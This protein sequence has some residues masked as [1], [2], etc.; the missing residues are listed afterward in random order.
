MDVLNVMVVL[1]D[2]GGP[3]KTNIKVR[4]RFDERERVF[5]PSTA[6]TGRT[7][8]EFRNDADINSIIA[9]YR[10]TG[11]LPP[12]AH[13]SAARFGDFSQIPDFTEMCARVDA[14]RDLFLALPSAVRKAFDH[15]P[16]KFIAATQSREGMEKL[17]ELGIAKKIEPILPPGS[18]AADPA[19]ASKKKPKADAPTK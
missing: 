5:S 17:V 18:G 7:K 4:T 6:G 10:R 13:R 8:Q 3:L 1:I 19:P 2:I 12:S 11:V 16:G 15:D 14:A 9:K